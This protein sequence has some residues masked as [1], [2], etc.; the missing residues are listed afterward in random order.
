MW[1]TKDEKDLNILDRIGMGL[2]GFAGQEPSE[3]RAK[4]QANARK[5]TY[6]QAVAEFLSGA[7]GGGINANG[8]GITGATMGKEGVNLTIGATP[9][10]KAEEAA[11]TAQIKEREVAIGKAERLKTVGQSIEKSWLKTSPYKGAI[12]K[13]GLVP[14]LGMWD[15]VKKGA[16]ATS[17]QRQDQAYA[18]FIS[19]VRAQLAR[20]MGDVGNLSEYEQR[21]VIQ[22]V[23]SLMDSL[24]SGQLKLGQLAQLVEDI[25]TTRGGKN[26]KEMETFE[27]KG[28]R[29][30]IPKD[31][32]EA[33]KKAKGL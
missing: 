33:F 4:A 8:M 24:E 23:P 29:Y 30:N 17:A 25:K 1:Q 32:V 15:I 3:I 7:R 6:E 9:L 18:S 5:N 10:A 28:V 12:T 20:G 16:G 2:S 31:K 22:L 14:V 26:G 27:V 13:T 19:G 11:Q 21:A